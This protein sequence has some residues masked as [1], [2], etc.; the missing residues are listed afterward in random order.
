MDDIRWQQ[1]FNNFIKA[2]QNMKDAVELAQQ[3]ELSKLEQQ[4]LIQGFEMTHELAWNVLKDYLEY[5]GIMNLVG[6][7]DAS[8]S[9]FANGLIE[10]GE[11]WLAMI[12]TRNITS[13]S[14]NQDA[15]SSAAQVIVEQ[16]YPAFLQMTKTF[17]QLHDREHNPG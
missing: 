4:G 2:F 6:S 10:D 5:Q 14:Y 16:Y 12:K 15:A 1:R 8:R 9:A 13:H 17:T 11:I 7:R 3:R